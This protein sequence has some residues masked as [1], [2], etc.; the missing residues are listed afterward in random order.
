M[1][2]IEEKKIIC[3]VSDEKRNYS[4]ILISPA[5]PFGTKAELWIKKGDSKWGWYV[6]ITK[7]SIGKNKIHWLGH[8]K[9]EWSYHSSGYK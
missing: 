5:I 8:S 2:K 4:N 9:L 7:D 6:G 3:I 1:W